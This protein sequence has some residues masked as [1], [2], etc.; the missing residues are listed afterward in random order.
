[1]PRLWVY[2]CEWMPVPGGV[3]GMQF[4]LLYVV[5][6]D[7]H[8]SFVRSAA[9]CHTLL[10]LCPSHH[11]FP[12]GLS[13]FELLF[14]LFS[15]IKN[16]RKMHGI[17]SDPY[18]KCYSSLLQW[19]PCHGTCIPHTW[20]DWSE[21][22]RHFWGEVLHGKAIAFLTRAHCVTACERV[23]MYFLTC[24]WT[25]PWATDRS[26]I[27]HRFRTAAEGKKNIFLLRVS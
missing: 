24:G 13:D 22:R 2:L 19:Q 1:M 4:M 10:C 3:P 6:K 16:I 12:R 7:V 20:I 17:V 26:E 23:L 14:S 21:K 8:D 9:W 27:L 5:C 18:E 25:L 11:W 15:H